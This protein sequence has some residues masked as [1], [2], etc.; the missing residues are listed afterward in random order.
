PPHTHAVQFYD[1]DEFLFETVGDFLAEGLLAGDHAIVIATEEHRQGFTRR[2]AMRGIEAGATDGRLT[3][4][5]ARETL[6]RFMVGDMPDRDLF[7][8]LL[9]RLME[10]PA[11]GSEPAPKLRA[12][13]EMV[14]VLWR[15]GNRSAAIRLEELWNEAGQEHSFSL[16]CAYLLG[17][18][19]H[20][21][22][23]AQFMDVCGRHSHVIP[24]EGF[25]QLEVGARSA[26][27]ARLQQRARLLE[28]ELEQRR[29]LEAS[30][31]EALSE[32]RTA[33]LA[34]SGALERER[35][36]RTLAEA[37][38]AFK[39][40]FLG[41]LGH[42][43]RNPLNN[44]LATARIMQMRREATQDDAKRLERIVSSGTRMARMIDQILDV[45]R[46]RLAGGI[47]LGEL[48]E[49]DLTPHVTR[50]VDEMRAV[51]P[52]REILLQAEPVCFARADGDR[53]EQVVSNLLGNAVAHGDP[54]R[55]ITLEVRA[56]AGKCRV[57]V[58]NYGPAIDPAFMPLL[59]DPFRREKP[60]SS[61]SGLGLGLY[62]SEQIIT[63]H[64]GELRVTSSAE[65]GTLFEVILPSQS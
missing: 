49:R 58:H 12:Y 34:L 60:C 7:R 2:L 8:K 53:F 15:D 9:A 33:E 48:T 36:A 30:L 6:A 35:E 62:I 27:V 10:R 52:S 28:G 5:D 4:L 57:C 18:F 55:P 24:A 63:L 22:D 44:V 3:L 29:A 39:E 31:R 26:E 38:A 13:G 64:G 20:E 14:D 1:S 37:S 59:F 51:H 11:A 25:A 45:T 32:T 47:P 21:G 56:Q 61:S 42:D 65:M 17:N 43:L 46:A 50:V 54:A 23:T 16:L 19:Y 40:T 41:I